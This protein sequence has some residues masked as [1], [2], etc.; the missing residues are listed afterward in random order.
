[1]YGHAETWNF[2]PFLCQG[3]LHLELMWLDSSRS[4]QFLLYC[5]FTSQVMVVKPIMRKQRQLYSPFAGRQALKVL[6]QYLAEKPHKFVRASHSITLK[7]GGWKGWSRVE[8][9]W[10][11]F[12]NMMRV[13]G[14]L[15]AS[16]IFGIANLAQKPSEPALVDHKELVK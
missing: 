12:I 13:G 3:C 7:P 16:P 5:L 15:C 2:L 9:I 11:D 10:W 8:G 6:L 1:M 14:R 4:N